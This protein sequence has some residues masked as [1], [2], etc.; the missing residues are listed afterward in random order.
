MS[1][2]VY[3]LLRQQEAIAENLVQRE[4]NLVEEVWTQLDFS[5]NRLDEYRKRKAELTAYINE[6][7][8][9]APS[10]N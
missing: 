4:L 7:Y 9:P 5:L 6:N 3:D 1:E 10:D 2:I 8:G